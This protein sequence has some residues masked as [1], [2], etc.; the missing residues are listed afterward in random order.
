MFGACKTTSIEYALCFVLWAAWK[1]FACVV[2]RWLIAQ[3]TLKCAQPL[4]PLKVPENP[5]FTTF[6]IS[7]T[8]V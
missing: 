4:G 3:K 2:Y 8:P 7:V 6:F 1:V 5:I